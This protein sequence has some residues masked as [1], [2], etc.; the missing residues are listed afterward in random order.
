MIIEEKMTAGEEVEQVIS[1]GGYLGNQVQSVFKQGIAR[2]R[3]KR[4]I[5]TEA[6]VV[7]GKYQPLRCR[8]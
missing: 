3:A 2:I 4:I 8:R 1:S 7:E 5:F 6:S